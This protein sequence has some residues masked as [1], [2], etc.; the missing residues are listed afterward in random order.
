MRLHLP[1]LTANLKNIG[2]L[3]VTALPMHAALLCSER[4]E[5]QCVRGR[6]CGTR[7]FGCSAAGLTALSSG[8]EI[9]V[10]TAPGVLAQSC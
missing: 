8:H 1:V 4:C 5:K 3:C 7:G 2:V 6:L 10:I 9:S